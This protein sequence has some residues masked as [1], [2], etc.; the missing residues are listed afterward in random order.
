MKTLLKTSRFVACALTSCTLNSE[1]CTQKFSNC[2]CFS[3]RTEPWSFP[4]SVF[5]FYSRTNQTETTA[6][7]SS[8]CGIKIQN[9]RCEL[10][11]MFLSCLKVMEIVAFLR[12]NC[13]ARENV[14]GL[15]H[16]WFRSSLVEKKK[17][18]LLLI[19]WGFFAVVFSANCWAWST[20]N[21][22]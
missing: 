18:V 12:P 5:V 6:K 22:R 13:Q 4:T 2:N 17:S 8:F 11:R 15:S 20:Y 19:G 1:P 7:V 14:R 9:V 16:C 10:G 3:E 21:Q